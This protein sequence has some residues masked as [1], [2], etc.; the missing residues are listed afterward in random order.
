MRGRLL[1]ESCEAE[2]RRVRDYLASEGQAGRP[3]LQAF[4]DAWQA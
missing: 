4:L 1:P 3:H 2:L